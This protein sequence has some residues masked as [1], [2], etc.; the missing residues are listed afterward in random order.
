M[1]ISDWSSDV[2]STDLFLVLSRHPLLRATPAW[3]PTRRSPFSRS[4]GGILPSSFNTVPSSASV[5]STSPPVSV[6]GTVLRWR[7]FLERSGRPPNPIRED[8]GSR[9]SRPPGPGILTWFPSTTAFALVLGEIG[10]AHV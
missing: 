1:R 4:Y 9:S 5:F 10:R 6:S 8:N 7:Y 2:C 3:L